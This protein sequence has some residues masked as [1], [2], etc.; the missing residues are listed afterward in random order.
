MEETKFQQFEIL[1]KQ[2]IYHTA[3]GYM[4][5]DFENGCGI[6]RFMKIF[7]SDNSDLIFG[8]LTVCTYKNIFES[9]FESIQKALKN[10]EI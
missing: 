2:L 7:C 5:R 3:R 8:L 1:K 6:S 10:L 9:E 4:E